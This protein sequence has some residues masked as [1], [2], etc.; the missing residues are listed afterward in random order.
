MCGQWNCVD[1]GKSYN[2]YVRRRFYGPPYELGRI[3]RIAFPMASPFAIFR[4][5]QR[6]WMAGAVFIAVVAFVISPAIQSFTNSGRPGGRSGANPTLASW[7]GGSIRLDQLEREYYELQMANAFLRK[8]AVEVRAQKGTPNVPGVSSDLSQLGITSDGDSRERI[9]ERKLLV[10]EANRRGIVFDDQSVKMFLQR[11]VDGKLDGNQIE[12]ALKDSTENRLSWF[13]FNRLMSEE[14]AKNQVLQ[15]GGAGVRFE[16]RRN[17]ITT[18]RPALSTPGKNWQDF[19]R[20]NQAARIQAFPIFAKDFESQVQGKP[21]EREIQ[22][23]YQAGKDFTR[24]ARTIATQPA[25]MRPKTADFEYLAIDMEKV[26]TEQMALIPEETL[27]ADYDRRV[28]EKQ[29]RVPVTPEATSTVIP[30]AKPATESTDPTTTPTT[31]Q[32]PA[33]ESKPATSDDQPGLPPVLEAPKPNALRPIRNPNLKL[34]SFQEETKPQET[35]PAPKAPDAA[36]PAAA[37]SPTPTGQDATTTPAVTPNAVQPPSDSPQKP[38]VELSEAA[39]PVV[40]TPSVSQAGDS[41][42]A[43]ST[44]MRT[45]TFEE[46][47]DQIAREQASGIAFKVVADRLDMVMGPMNIY[48]SQLVSYQQ[49]V[50]MKDK[51]AKAPVRPDLKELGAS[52]GF[53]H[54]T[55]GMVDTDNVTLSPIGSS[56]VMRGQRQQAIPFSALINESA[57]LGETYMPLLSLGFTGGNK[58]F[59]FWKT[60][61]IQPVTPSLESV[62]TQIEEVWRNQQAFKLAETRA[63]ELASKVGSAPLADS[64]ATPEERALIL[65]PASFTWYNP[66][67]ARTESRMQISTVELLQPVD[68]QFMEAVFASQPGETTVAPDMNKTV[69]YVVKV[70]EMTPDMNTL[71]ERF[72]S[73]PLEGVATLSRIE[74]DRAIQPWFQNLQKQLGFRMD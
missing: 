72:A 13:D 55:T 39:P 56:I 21:T 34:V 6:L 8:L 18:G 69:Y 74:S 20:L 17:S 41:P 4:K 40:M 66:M 52:K 9:I 16:E 67:F 19:L 22:D 27:R 44:P 57:G 31:E 63:R 61:E 35:D 5:N 68:Y 48:K 15:L 62:R 11:F 23:L 2:P 53:E 70:V 26:I 49:A 50:A 51:T 7:T 33:P 14:M 60:D 59:A 42:V 25:F 58:R 71:L 46:V 37:V 24:M 29:F 30:D 43:E 1:R 64:L 38:S 3:P 45:K 65:E 47:R 32:T 36:S 54:G 73:S 12:K 10:A 28:G